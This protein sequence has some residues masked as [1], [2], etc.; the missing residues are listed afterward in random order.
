MGEEIMNEEKEVWSYVH[1]TDYAVRAFDG[2][3][4]NWRELQPKA[5]PYYVLM[6]QQVTFHKGTACV[7][8]IIYLP[9]Q[10]MTHQEFHA[11]FKHV[12]NNIFKD[13]TRT[14]FSAK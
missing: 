5:E 6:G 9:W 12:H 3:K 4:D 1:V 7:V 10:F 13:D 14:L 8:K 11:K 2:E